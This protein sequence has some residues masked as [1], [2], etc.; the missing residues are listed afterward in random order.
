MLLVHLLLLLSIQIAVP[1]TCDY[2]LTKKKVEMRQ[3][4]GCVHMCWWADNTRPLGT[5]GEETTAPPLYPMA[6]ALGA[7]AISVN[8]TPNR[9]H[10]TVTCHLTP[11]PVARAPD[12]GHVEIMALQVAH[13]RPVQNKP[14][15]ALGGL[16]HFWCPHRKR[17]MFF[18]T[19][20]P[21]LPSSC[22]TLSCF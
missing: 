17:E 3:E 8:R 6:T 13:S 16:E 4:R 7:L 9:E 12:T 2:R 5:G 19:V 11:Y 14:S 1:L 18:F 15:P 20:S 21:S 22:S 10:R